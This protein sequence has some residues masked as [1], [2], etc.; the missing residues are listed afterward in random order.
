MGGKGNLLG[1]ILAV[2]IIGFLNFGL[3]L[4]NIPTQFMTILLGVLLLVADGIAN[5][6]PSGIDP[7][8]ILKK[9]QG[10]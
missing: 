2:F 1:S 7:R 10:R 5:N 3:G 9:E 6:M 8:R 4:V